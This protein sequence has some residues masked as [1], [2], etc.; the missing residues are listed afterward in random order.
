MKVNMV[1]QIFG[2]CSVDPDVSADGLGE[3][4]TTTVTSLAPLNVFVDWGQGSNE[5]VKY[6]PFV[7]HALLS[8]A[9]RQLEAKLK[10]LDNINLNTKGAE[11]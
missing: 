10:A 6:G 3:L 7:I 5:K 4:I 11:C 8:E 1:V 2:E 9:L